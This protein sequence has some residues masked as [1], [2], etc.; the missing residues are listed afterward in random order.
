[1]YPDMLDATL[2]SLHRVKKLTVFG[3]VSELCFNNLLPK[4]FEIKYVFY[5][6][7]KG[8]T[9]VKWE[10]DTVTKVKVQEGDT[11]NK[12]TG[13]AL[14]HMKR[15]YEVFFKKSDFNKMLKKYAECEK[16]DNNE[17]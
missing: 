10:D 14:C 13:L 17:K 15:I 4:K 12:E 3:N 5:N 8:V 16:S 6:E 2:D 1:M 11:F 7:Q 9:V